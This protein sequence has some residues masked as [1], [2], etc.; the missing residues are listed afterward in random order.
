MLPK[1]TYPI[2]VF[3]QP[4][5]KKKLKF[6]PFLVKEEK[7]LLMA[8]QS[9]S[10]QEIMQ[11]VKSILQDCCQ[12]KDFDVNQI[13]IFDLEI[14][15][16]RI[17]AVSVNN[18]EKIS[19]QDDE[20]QQKYNL[21]ID[22]N[23]VNLIYPEEVASNK[24]Q[25]GKDI[26]IVMKYPTSDIFEEE[27]IEKKFNKEGVYEL[28]L[29]CIDKIF[30]KDTLLKFTLEE[31]KEFLENLDIKTFNKMRDFLLSIPKLELRIEYKNKFGNTRTILFNSLR[32]FFIFL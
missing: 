27:D 21:I 17:R 8:K 7:V 26:T 22:L 19:I 20:D 14:L 16:L 5:T 18:V 2:S 15:F 11:A 31:K 32:D 28:V 9:E 25:V 6:R 24:I 3:E 23:S 29:T 1:I 13:P 30:D 12:E 10:F 4:S